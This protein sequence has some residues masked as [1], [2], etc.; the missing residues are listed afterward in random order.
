MPVVFLVVGVPA[1]QS[2]TELVAA[3]AVVVAVAGAD[4]ATL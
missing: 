2:P 3:V 4:A 1:R